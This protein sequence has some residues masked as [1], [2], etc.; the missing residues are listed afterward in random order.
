[1]WKMGN[2]EED[3]AESFLDENSEGIC[4]LSTTQRIYA[5]AA[6]LLSGLVLMFLSLIVFAIPIKFALLFTFGNVLAVGSTAF[7]MGPEQQLRMMFDSV[8]VYATVIYI[9]FVILALICALWIQSK[10]LTLLAI[11]CEI[12]AL[13]WYCLSYIP[14]ARR[15]V[16]DLMVRFCDTEL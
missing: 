16:S 3:R 4:S 14:F 11:I 12:C 10:I 6:C 7:L 5:S 2:D 15:I 9:G 13:I 1:M 8:R